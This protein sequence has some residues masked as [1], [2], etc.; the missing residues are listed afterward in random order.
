[1]TITVVVVVVSSSEQQE[2]NINPII[3]VKICLT[4]LSLRSLQQTTGFQ[5]QIRQ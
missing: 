5:F 2:T 3:N 1:L 4:I